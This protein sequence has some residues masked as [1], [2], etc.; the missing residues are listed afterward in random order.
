MFP[1]AGCALTAPFHPYSAPKEAERYLS[2]ALVLGSPPA[3][4]T[5]Y[6]CP[7]EPGLS[8]SGSFR[9]PSAAVR[10]GRGFIVLH[11]EEKVKC[12]AN[13]FPK[14]YTIKGISVLLSKY[15]NWN[16]A[17]RFGKRAVR[18]LAPRVYEGGVTSAHTG[19]GGSPSPTYLS[20]KSAKNKDGKHRK[21][22]LF[23]ILLSG[24]CTPP[25]PVYAT[26]GTPLTSAG[27]KAA[28]R[29]EP[30][31]VHQTALQIPICRFAELTR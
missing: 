24:I 31:T 9:F 2:V 22:I 25:A 13:S 18:R 20:Q 29:I 4:V 21:I 27:G 16:L 14:G 23:D 6:P 7:V 12:L 11:G 15:I 3:G 26:F 5:R 30:Q 19:D 1:W 17:A 10:P 28:F 8:S